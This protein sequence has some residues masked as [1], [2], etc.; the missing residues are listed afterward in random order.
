MGQGFCIP[1]SNRSL[2]SRLMVSICHNLLSTFYFHYIFHIAPRL[3]HYHKPFHSTTQ[4]I[5]KLMLLFTQHI[6]QF[7]STYIK[8]NSIPSPC[9]CPPTHHHRTIFLETTIAIQNHIKQTIRIVIKDHNS[10]CTRN[11][12]YSSHWNILVS[13]FISYII[14]ENLLHHIT[15][16]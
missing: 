3:N 13:V 10:I 2:K 8:L 4:L 9:L 12:L 14:T 1:T 7:I 11:C 5:S 16:N 6:C 15:T